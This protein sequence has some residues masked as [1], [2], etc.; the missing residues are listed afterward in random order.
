MNNYFQTPDWECKPRGSTSV[1]SVTLWFV[2]FLSNKNF[3][4]RLQTGEVNQ[5]TLALKQLTKNP[6]IIPKNIINTEQQNNQ[7]PNP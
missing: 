3:T 1:F 6:W 5:E 2:S 7:S 4:S